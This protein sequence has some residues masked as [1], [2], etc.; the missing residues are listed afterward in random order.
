VL[1]LTFRKVMQTIN[2]QRTSS[3]H[4]NI[5]D[6]KHKPSKPHHKHSEIKENDDED[7]DEEEEDEEYEEEEEESEDEESE[8]ER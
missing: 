2:S 7:E 5:R 4:S 1:I 3:K 8:T 6:G